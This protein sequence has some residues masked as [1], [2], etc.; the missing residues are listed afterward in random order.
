M[1]SLPISMKELHLGNNLF[2]ADPTEGHLF[3]VGWTSTPSWG[4]PR[5]FRILVVFLFWCRPHRRPPQGGGSGPVPIHGEVQETADSCHGV[6]G[7]PWWRDERTST[8]SLWIK[9]RDEMSPH[10]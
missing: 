10:E 3:V 5:A 2:T 7:S 4:K 6:S 1:A 8:H 9:E